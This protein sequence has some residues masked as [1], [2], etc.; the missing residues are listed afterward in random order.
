LL[1]F[2]PVFPFRPY[3]SVPSFVWLSASVS[4]RQ[5]SQPFPLLLSVV[6]SV[7][8]SQ[9]G[10]G[11]LPEEKHCH[12]GDWSLVGRSAKCTCSGHAVLTRGVCVCPQ[13]EVTGHHHHRDRGPAECVCGS[14]RE[15]VAWALGWTGLGA[16]S[17]HAFADRLLIRYQTCLSLALPVHQMG[18]IISPSQGGS[19]G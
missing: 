7:Q 16:A 13:L 11:P 4:L 2:C 19:W 15:D 18:V 3:S 14:P 9:G 6:G 5:E 8:F 17:G 1:W 12:R 10:A